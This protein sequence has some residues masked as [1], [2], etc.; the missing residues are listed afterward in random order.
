MPLAFGDHLEGYEILAPLG[1]GGMGEVWLA[2]DP[3]PAAQGRLKLLP[4]G[5]TEDAAR[6]VARF[7]QEARLGWMLDNVDT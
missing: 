1:A 3:A 7:Q 5:L 6:V 2:S 4:A